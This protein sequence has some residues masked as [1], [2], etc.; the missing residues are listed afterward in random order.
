MPYK[1]ILVGTDGSE[2]AGVAVSEAIALAKITGAALHAVQVVPPVIAAG[3]ADSRS[4]QVE[5]DRGRDEAKQVMDRIVDEAQREGV[6][7]EVHN[8]GNSDP[9]DGLI[10]TAETLDADLVVVGNRGITGVKSFFLGSVPSKVTQRCSR[11]V[12]IVNTERT[13]PG[14]Y[15]DPTGRH[16]KRHWDGTEWTERVSDKGETASDPL[17]QSP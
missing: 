7:V 11:S 1:V 9:A 13:V 12:L 17:Q 3:F 2:R 5:I 4:D 14:W 15:P 16:E 8:P 6:G 10:E